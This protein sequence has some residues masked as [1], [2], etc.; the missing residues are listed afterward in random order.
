MAQDQEKDYLNTDGMSDD[1]SLESILAE[2]KGSAF[3]DGDKK[4]PPHILDEKAQRIV[5]EVTGTGAVSAGISSEGGAPPE[6]ENPPPPRKEAAAASE[7]FKDE[8]TLFFENFRYSSPDTPADIADEVAEAVKK[9]LALEQQALDGA[10]KALGIF[11]GD[12]R[13]ARGRRPVRAEWS[14]ETQAEPDFRERA[15]A[16]GAACNAL[17]WRAL[18]GFLISII[19]LIIT[20][21]FEAG[22]LLPF[23]I[24]HSRVIASG[25]LLIL[26]LIVMVIGA[27]ALV[28]G[29]ESLVKGAPGADTLVFIASLVCVLSGIYYLK[30]PGADGV[31]P[32]SA[33]CSFS[34]SFAL[35]GERLYLQALADTLRTAS[36]AAEPY[37]IVSEFRED[38]DRTILKKTS[39]RTKGFYS[40]L[41]QADICETAYAY[42]APVLLTAAVVI[43]LLASFT[44]SELSPIPHSLSAMISAA[45]VFPAAFAFAAPFR[46]IAIKARRSGAAIAGAGGADDIY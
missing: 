10:A 20:F 18:A 25:V 27:D 16:F 14:A 23:G 1:F 4:T 8:D 46:S 38:M 3:I 32:Y 21:G 31:L 6:P 30:A 37:A 35:W 33:V 26:Q 11:G 7:E 5:M 39:R 2:Y 43:A 45:A 40:N 36:T 44:H 29:A 24:G 41:M 9:E 42:A 17:A 19:M 34:L 12:A 28:K 22:K 15:G 13:A